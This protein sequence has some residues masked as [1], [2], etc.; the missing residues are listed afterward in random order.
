[1]SSRILA[2]LCLSTLGIAPATS[3]KEYLRWN[4]DLSCELWA[5]KESPLMRSKSV[6]ETLYFNASA[7]TVDGRIFSLSFSDLDAKYR[8]AQTHERKFE[9]GSLPSKTT[10]RIGMAEKKA[11]FD[12]EF[13]IKRDGDYIDTLIKPSKIDTNRFLAL[14]EIL[15]VPADEIAALKSN[16]TALNSITWGKTQILDSCNSAWADGG[17]IFYGR[18]YKDSSDARM[19]LHFK[20]P[21]FADGAS[22][23]VDFRCTGKATDI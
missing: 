8:P 18:Y 15:A 21:K 6:G 11:A 23:H 20:D 14:L 3:A 5:S 19:Q 9:L 4:V 17:S 2:L 1:M 12:L 13:E 7:Q 10:A 16:P 22:Y